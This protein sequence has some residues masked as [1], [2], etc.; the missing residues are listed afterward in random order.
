MVEKYP[1]P[2]KASPYNVIG[3]FK[4]AFHRG[5]YESKKKKREKRKTYYMNVIKEHPQRKRLDHNSDM[6]LITSN[7]V[8][9]NLVNIL[10]IL[11]IRLK[12]PG[13]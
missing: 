2:F 9:V 8:S 5:L 13:E 12:T 10:S 6:C 4:Q 7:L 11:S 3:P 1:R